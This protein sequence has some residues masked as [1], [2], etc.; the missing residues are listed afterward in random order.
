MTSK[1]SSSNLIATLWDVL[2]SAELL[3]V[4]YFAA[5]TCAVIA[6]VF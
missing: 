5:I 1:T 6:S 4:A 3:P 2:P